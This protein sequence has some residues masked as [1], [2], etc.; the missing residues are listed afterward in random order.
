MGLSGKN[1]AGRVPAGRVPA[2]S[3]PGD[4]P[5]GRVLPSGALAANVPSIRLTVAAS[6]WLP[7]LSDCARL[8]AERAEFARRNMVCTG[9][10]DS[11]IPC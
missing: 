8:R 3:V 7:R 2:G 10:T 1:P 6:A 5:A 11:R 9:A 4:R